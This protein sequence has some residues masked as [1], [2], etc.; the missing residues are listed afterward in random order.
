MRPGQVIDGDTLDAGSLSEKRN[1]SIV[2]R[3]SGVGLMLGAILAV[4]Q[5]ACGGIS[6]SEMAAGSTGD[7]GARATAESVSDFPITVYTGADTL[8]GSEINFSDL[9]G[10]PVVLNFWA[11]LCP[12]CRAEMPDLQEFYDEFQDRTVMI[13][14]DVGQFT[15]LGNQGDAKS[16]LEALKIT[17]PTGFTRERAV[18]RDYGVF[19]M[20]TTVFITS[21]GQV[22]RKWSG[23]LNR[24]KLAEITN[25]MLS[26]EPG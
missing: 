15:G 13:G 12:P 22:F 19:S 24:E 8:G 7:A 23:V 26:Q 18:M 17:Y 11:G 4:L 5:V 3:G 9:R 16:L 2:R 10:Q 6:T 21:E 14:I 1:L 20:P 25:E